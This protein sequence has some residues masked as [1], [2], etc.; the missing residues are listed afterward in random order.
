MTKKMLTIPEYKREVGVTIPS[1]R[2]D[3][4]RGFND[5]FFFRAYTLVPRISFQWRIQNVDE[6]SV[7]LS[8]NL[9]RQK[10]NE[11]DIQSSEVLQ[12][13]N[14]DPL[15]MG[16]EFHESI[17]GFRNQVSIPRNIKPDYEQ[18]T[19]LFSRLS[20]SDPQEEV[21]FS[22]R[23]L[24]FVMARHGY[25]FV[26]IFDPD[27]SYQCAVIKDTTKN[28][29]YFI[30]DHEEAS[31]R[32]RLVGSKSMARTQSDSWNGIIETML[33]ADYSNFRE[34]AKDYGMMIPPI[35][36]DIQGE[37]SYFNQYFY[38][39]SQ[40]QKSDFDLIYK[41]GI[42]V[43]FQTPTELRQKI[44]AVCR[45]NAREFFIII[46]ESVLTKSVN[47]TLTT[48][49]TLIEAAPDIIIGH[50]SRTSYRSFSP[51]ELLSSFSENPLDARFI[52][53]YNH[54][55]EFDEGE[56]EK[57]KDLL[58]FFEKSS[59][60]ACEACDRID[61]IL[62]YQAELTEDVRDFLRKYQ[63]SDSEYKEDFKNLI[64]NIFYAGMY[65]RQWRG[66]EHPFPVTG[67]E[68]RYYFDHDSE[69]F[70]VGVTKHMTEVMALLSRLNCVHLNRLHIKSYSN[71]YYNYGYRMNDFLRNVHTG[72]YCIRMASLPLVASAVF[73]ST[74]LKGDYLPKISLDGFDSI[75]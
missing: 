6:L 30:V 1:V 41:S 68:T 20:S 53:P 55:E 32:A 60:I 46:T 31:R 4:F 38:E 66:P 75:L 3:Y 72:E 8:T 18:Y 19:N 17:T 14:S 11:L 15:S 37:M 13:Y 65:M 36:T 9:V 10:A 70:Y 50:G 57:I 7:D 42:I 35:F 25:L 21:T 69:E 54:N 33:V 61:T 48:L 16:I 24:R 45:R 26:T 62:K 67:S 40:Q 63:S 51:V 39:H 56:V 52:K 2:H 5:K 44:S 12:M 73:Y 64:T 23:F 49:E 47:K 22:G 34:I 29:V 74:L 59:S 28:K 58:S 43:Y 71:Y 27:E